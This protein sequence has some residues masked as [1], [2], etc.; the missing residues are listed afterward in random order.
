MAGLVILGV[1]SWAARCSP[2]GRIRR[3]ALDPGARV[4]AARDRRPAARPLEEIAADARRLARHFHHQPR[5][6]SFAKYEA[7]RR[8]Y[9]DV[10]AE[11]CR[12][13]GASTTCWAS[14]SPAAS[15]TRSAPGS[16]G[17]LECAGLELGLAL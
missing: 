14:S 1:M 2:G 12:A 15:W 9:D 5:G 7:H 10:L 6:Q 3:L 8:A 11:G 16:S 13:L 4:G 17:V